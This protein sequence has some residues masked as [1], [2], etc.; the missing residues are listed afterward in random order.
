MSFERKK[1]VKSTQKR[2]AKKPIQVKKKSLQKSRPSRSRKKKKWVI[3]AKRIRNI[4]L[5]LIIFFILSGIVSSFV[6]YQKYLADLPGTQEL[7]DLE[8]K[9]TSTIY[10]KDWNQLYNV[11]VEKRTYIDYAK[12]SDNIINALIAWE[13]QRYWENPGIDLIWLSR[14]AFYYAIGK[15]DQVKWTSTITQQL[16]SNTI[17][18]N[19]R[20]IATKIQEMYLSRK[21]TK[22]LTKE[23]IL[24]LYLNKIS[25]GW[26]AY[27]I[28]QA[29]K[30]FF[31]KSALDINVLEASILASLPKGPTYYS[32]YSNPDRL[33]WYPYTYIKEDSEVTTE[34]MTATEVKDNAGKIQKLQDFISGLK[35]KRLS[36]SKAL[37]CGL[38]TA[39]VKK[40]ISVDS[41]GCSVVA[42]SNL[43]VLLNGIRIEDWENVIEYQTGRKDFILQRMLEDSY[44]DFDE[45]KNS[46]LWS[47][48]YTF[49]EYKEDIKYPHFVFYVKEYIEEKYGKDLLEKWGLKIYTTLDPKLQDEAQRLV[50]KYG[51]ANQARYGAKNSSL[52]SID[53]ATGRVLAMVWWRDYFD[54]ENKWNVNITTSRLQ[55]GSSFKPFVYALA[56]DQQRIGTKTPVYDLETKFPWDYTPWN[57]D[58]KFK[59][60]MTIMEALNTSRNIPAV[61]MF[62][63]AG[64]ENKILNFM[65][66]L[67]VT[68]PSDFK[69]EYLKNYEKEYSYWAS[70]ALGTWLMTPLELASAYSVFANMWKKVDVNPIAK[71]LDSKG[72]VIEEYQE[73]EAPEVINPSLAYIMN[74]VLSNTASRPDSWNEYLAMNGRP[75][76]AKTGTST[77]QY[78]TG[79]DRKIF[80]RNLWTAGYTPQITTVVWSGN[81]DGKELHEKWSWLRWAWPIWKD[82]MEFSHRDKAVRSWEKTPWIKEVNI[83]S[84]SWLL[85]P[86]SLSWRFIT[87]SLFLNPPEAYWRSYIWRVDALCN[88]AV[89]ENTPEAAIKNISLL[90]FSS[91]R[92]D[93][94]EW[95]NPVKTW[96]ANA[97]YRWEFGWI[98]NN[99]AT[100]VSSKE[101]ER[102]DLPSDIIIRTS[103]PNGASFVRGTNF[104]EVAYRSNHPISRL[105]IFVGWKSI[106]QVPLAWKN[107]WAYKWSFELPSTL[108]WSTQLTVRAVDT[109][110]FSKEETKTI[111]I[112]DRDTTPPVIT[113][114][115]PWANTTI[116]SSETV[117][118]TWYVSDRS[119]IKSINIYSDGSPIK[120][121]WEWR[122]FNYVLRWSELWTWAHIIEIE[123]IDN[124][125]N[126][127][128]K[129][130]TVNVTAAPKSEETQEESEETVVESETD[131]TSTWVLDIVEEAVEN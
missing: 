41:D 106:A 18:W 17:I 104:I 27:G 118:I 82:F 3:M 63:V 84:V 66:T 128:K 2:K 46:L 57:F 115:S 112:I 95:E 94:F 113:V 122:S 109:Q 59:G 70:L 73:T 48:G 29:S 15:T 60:K 55:P 21:I 72:L 4:V 28:E 131:A 78:G 5:F 52:I 103:T 25:F 40:H 35:L 79:D 116:S 120:I 100:Y 49:N 23:K 38:D 101:C 130:I 32:P 12:I 76:A 64:W 93:N 129:A 107:Q 91:L 69:E 99:V 85:P 11:F 24:E 56:F 50:E 51:A 22:D 86:W 111:N 34:I 42:Y 8:I 74:Y 26:N 7:R 117:R 53:N 98:S 126:S 10:D 71:I 14:A 114:S 124:G 20:A 36:N 16:I 45:Y 61:K 83:S 43:L 44:I 19:E 88:G 119:A 6:L 75:V 123:A 81:T 97:G 68:T 77:K 108:T 80:P 90:R 1:I 47:F 102:S 9:E 65:K 96:V 30:T 110:Y 125:L 87:D 31:W 121:G 67:W 127:S 89:T 13:D 37:I 39:N 105:D 92:P 58:G 33:L 62:F 54:K